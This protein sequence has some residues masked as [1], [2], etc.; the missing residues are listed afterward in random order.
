[1][2]VES[3]MIVGPEYVPCRERPACLGL[4][5]FGKK[6]TKGGRNMKEA[7]K[8]THSTE[9]RGKKKNLGSSDDT[10]RR[11]RTDNRKHY[12]LLHTVHD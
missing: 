7:R 6:V 5:H 8:V 9:K 3:N 4:F 12:Y 11:F 2:K 1:M 10:D